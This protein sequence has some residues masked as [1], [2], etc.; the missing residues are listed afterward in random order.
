MSRG[1]S[2]AE[3]NAAQGSHRA[4]VLLVDVAFTSGTLR[5]ALAPWNIPVGSDIYY[6]SGTLLSIEE[7][8]ES[9][10]NT[11]GIRLTLSGLDPAAIAI[12]AGEHIP[13]RIVRLLKGY[14]DTST[15]QLVDAPKVTWIGRA[16][17][18]PIAETGSTC[19]ITL[20]AEHYGAEHERPFPVRIND[21]E[22][23]RRHPGDRGCEYVDQ[24]VEKTLYWPTKEAVERIQE[25]RR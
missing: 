10:F 3:I 1:L 7:V 23:K 19:Q 24:M 25:G 11:E 20:N 13:G 2:T 16:L 15:Y 5:L 21:A 18:M 22:Q 9:A 8:R 4:V 14:L 12:A 6:A 17:S